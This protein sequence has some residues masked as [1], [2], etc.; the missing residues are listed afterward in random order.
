MRLFL[1]IFLTFWITTMLMLA[2][3]FSASEILPLAFH[4]EHKDEFDPELAASSLAVDVNM[5]EQQ[6]ATAFLSTVQNP[7]TIHHGSIYLFGENRTLLV[8]SGNP[9]PIFAEM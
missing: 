3:T 6:G 8:G 1:R 5:Y 9:G 7:S 4:Q 2:A